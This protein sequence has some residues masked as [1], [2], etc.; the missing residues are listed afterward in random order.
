MSNKL[1]I[2]DFIIKGHDKSWFDEVKAVCYLLERDIL[3]L[4]QRKY[5]EDNVE[6]P[7]IEP[8]TMVIFMNCSDVFAW[9]CADGFSI[10]Y[11]HNLDIEKN[12]LYRL[13][14]Y[15]LADKQHYG[16]I[17]YAC[18]KQNMQPQKA[19]VADLKHDGVWDSWWEDLPPNPDMVHCNE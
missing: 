14:T 2:E 16:V 7:T 13:L 9:G 12:E 6:P 10:T 3:F 5:I 18:W 19:I 17:K 11:S 15:V 4:N 1:T 8:K